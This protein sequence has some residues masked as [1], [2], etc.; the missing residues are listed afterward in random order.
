MKYFSNLS[1]D[2]TVFGVSLITSPDKAIKRGI[3]FGS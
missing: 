2:N 3:S 1:T